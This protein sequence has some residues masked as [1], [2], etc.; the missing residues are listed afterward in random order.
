M[1]PD[2]RIQFVCI[3]TAEIPGKIQNV[4]S[5][6]YS[7]IT[8]LWGHFINYF[9]QFYLN[10]FNFK[11]EGMYTIQHTKNELFVFLPP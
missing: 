4:S 9:L 2:L 6:T 11:T 10:F 1:E 8:L 5:V 3:Y 7:S